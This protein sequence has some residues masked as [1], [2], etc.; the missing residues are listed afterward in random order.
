MDDESERDNNEANIDLPSDPEIS[1][2][3]L[4]G[5]TAAKTMRITA[6]IGTYEGIVLID[7]G[8]T[9]NFISDKVAGLLRL[10]VVPTEPF[11]GIPFSITFYSLPLTGLDLVLGVQ[12]LEQ[13]GLVVCDWKKMTMEFQWANKP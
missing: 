8:S 5:W 6:K 13:L 12:W 2:H 1:L 11:N 3:A 9:H 7:S 10:P 4:T